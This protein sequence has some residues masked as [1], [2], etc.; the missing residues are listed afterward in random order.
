MDGMYRVKNVKIDK[1]K[2]VSFLLSIFIFIGNNGNSS[3]L[4]M[5]F[6]VFKFDVVEARRRYIFV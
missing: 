5:T 4:L 6:A 2:N 3:F 1:W